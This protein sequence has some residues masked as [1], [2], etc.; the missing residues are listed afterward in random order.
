M[1]EIHIKEVFIVSEEYRVVSIIVFKS[2]VDIL[3]FFLFV[4]YYLNYT[5][6]FYYYAETILLDNLYDLL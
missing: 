5:N 2:F 6:V 3:V 1:I 4:F